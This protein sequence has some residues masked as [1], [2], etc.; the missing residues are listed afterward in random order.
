[1]KKL[2]LVVAAALVALLALAGVSA[3]AGD[4]DSEGKAFHARLTGFEEIKSASEGAISTTG[5]GSFAARLRKDPPRIEYRLRYADLEGTAA[6]AHIHLG[7]AH[8]VGGV[9][10]F[11]CGGGD[12]DP[13]PA[14]GTVTG[15][16][17]ALDVIGPTSQGIAA[18]ELGE[19]VRAMRFGATYA[20]VHTDKYPTGE[21]RGQ[22]RGHGGAFKLNGGEK[23]KK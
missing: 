17:D 10:A 1:M 15:T 14:Q 7:Q 18:G 2:T 11:L 4:G 23:E 21:I 5:H 19:L 6:A 9:S 20:N 3:F 13:C 16:I 12:K 22:I 8:T